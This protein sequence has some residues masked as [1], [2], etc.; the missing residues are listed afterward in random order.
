MWRVF[1]PAVL[2]SITM[3]TEEETTSSSTTIPIPPSIDSTT[4]SFNN[5]NIVTNTIYD[6]N[7]TEVMNNI[8]SIIES[9]TKDNIKSKKKQYKSKYLNYIKSR[10]Y[11]KQEYSEL[12]K[13]NKKSKIEDKFE[14]FVT[15]E[16]YI[17]E[18]NNN[19]LS[20]PRYGHTKFSDW[21]KE[22]KQAVLMTKQED[23]EERRRLLTSCFSF[24]GW[25][26][27]VSSTVDYRWAAQPIQDQS[28][29]GS[30]WA[31]ASIAQYEFNYYK[32][33]SIWSKQNEQYILDC[34]GDSIGNCVGGWPHQTNQWLG[35]YGSCPKYG[36][37]L[38]DAKDTWSCSPSCWG[39]KTST[40]NARAACIT[41]SSTGYDS[42]NYNYWKI[43]AN[44]AQYV[45]LAFW[46]GISNDFF[47]LKSYDTSNDVK[48]LW[49]DCDTSNMNEGTHAMAIYGVWYTGDW[50][51]IR[52]SWGD[53]WGDD[54]YFW[55]SSGS[56]ANCNF[57]NYVSFNYWS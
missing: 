38:Y 24:S 10:N 4:I 28:G 8:S 46:M 40:T 48:S 2:I 11:K 35:D 33:K 15:S 39:T 49:Y 3:A 32:Y 19:N 17:N 20:N 7:E 1:I 36:Y 52:N 6:Y 25:G 12:I 50:L 23:E 56:I 51:L 13:N 29:C 34:V 41:E 14:L 21:S 55:L 9:S 5:S 53:D 31:F 22:E 27:T 45:S 37:Y 26:S 30:C 16:D 42:E 44:A 43:I 18:L 54:G 57:Q 47:Y